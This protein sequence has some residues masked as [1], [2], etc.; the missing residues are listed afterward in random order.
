M[1]DMNLK[2]DLTQDGLSMFFKDYELEALK[3]LWKFNPGLISREVWEQVNQHPQITISRASIIN[4][5]ND[6]T[7]LGILDASTE[8][9]KGGH[10][11]RY[12]PKYDEAQTK[13]YLRDAVKNKLNAL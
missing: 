9:G 7:E 3:L 5:L 10:R 11:S 13:Q 6:M 12:S 4:F 2:M 8:T 1:L